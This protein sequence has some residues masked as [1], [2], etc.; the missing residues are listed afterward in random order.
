MKTLDRYIV[1]NFL[2]AVLLC[3]LA[4]LA[5]RISADLMFNMDE[6]AETKGADERSVSEI[7]G[8]I[9]SY[10]SHRCLLYFREMGGVMIGVAAA[11]TLARMNHS[12]E[13]TAVLA[14]GVSL[15]RVLLPIAMCAIGLN[16]LVVIDTEL[17]IPRFK[18]AL[19]RNRDEQK[20]LHPF[21]VRAVTDGHNACWQ[22]ERLD[23]K[24]GLL[25]YPM[26]MLRD[27][28]YVGGPRIVADEGRYD[29]ANAE[30]VFYPTEQTLND[31]TVQPPHVT[32]LD[33]PGAKASATSR[34]VPT[35]LDPE[36]MVRA[37]QRKA[38]AY[39]KRKNKVL[40]INWQSVTAILNAYVTE[41]VPKIEKRV[42]LE[43]SAK[44]LE[45]RWSGEKIAAAVLKDAS[46]KY[47]AMD[48]TGNGRP[49]GTF[50]ADEA[51]Y[52]PGKE[53]EAGWLLTNGRLT[54]QSDLTPANL[55]LR[56]AGGWMT[57]MST[58]EIGQLL[59]LKRAGD[60]EAGR[61]L[62]HSRFA[63]FFVNIIMLLMGV[64]FILSRERDLKSS[65]GLTLAVVGGVYV[66]VYLSRYIGL[67][68]MLAAWIPVIVF[69]V[70]S[71]FVL[72]AVKT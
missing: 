72:E 36:E 13:L 58:A 53:G 25:R 41:D 47:T 46:F 61:L 35:M 68:A 44:R 48:E 55:R 56:Q 18:E 69:G 43:I 60:P 3:F 2:T 66:C 11:F 14:S 34:L 17:V 23:P 38:K 63:N 71:V 32:R 16:M 67:P 10:Y 24:S 4:L 31:E 6:F 26:V 22:S 5:I 64:P 21:Q 27:D 9:V 70:A 45:L 8:E 40:R 37:A 30:W 62:R 49:M 19:I 33:L 39:A 15:H 65:A 57:L 51:V 42:K 12:N 54:Y 50:R 59:K 29:E 28:R 1:K 52:E 7:S 20:G